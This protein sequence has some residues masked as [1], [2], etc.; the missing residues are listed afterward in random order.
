VQLPGLVRQARNL[1]LRLI[2]KITPT[3]IERAQCSALQNLLIYGVSLEK[4]TDARAL[5]VQNSG[6]EEIDDL[7]NKDVFDLLPRFYMSFSEMSGAY[8]L[9][10]AS[11]LLGKFDFT[12]AGETIRLKREEDKDKFVVMLA[13]L[14][15]QQ[16]KQ[17]EESEGGNVPASLKDNILQL[18]QEHQAKGLPDIKD[19]FL[20]D[21]RDLKFLKLSLIHI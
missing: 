9:G 20:I 6:L 19:T 11:L 18:I 2:K 1:C 12:A 17:G 5:L 13:E 7:L 16:N 4:N 3:G 15:E 14:L 8:S 10:C 21:K